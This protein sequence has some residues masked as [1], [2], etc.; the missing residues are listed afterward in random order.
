MGDTLDEGMSP[1]FIVEDVLENLR[2]L[3][4]RRILDRQ[5]L[6]SYTFFFSLVK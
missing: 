6:R 3:A 1:P 5:V 4:R 2:M